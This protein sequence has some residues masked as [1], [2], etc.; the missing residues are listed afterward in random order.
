V[1][2]DNIVVF[3]PGRTYMRKNRIFI[4]QILRE[5]TEHVLAEEA[6]HHVSR[7]LRLR[8]GHPLILFNGRGGEYDAEISKKYKRNVEV[9]IK[10]FRDVDNESP[11]NITLAQGISKGQKMDFTIQKAVEMGVNRIV[12]VLTEYG[13]VQLDVKRLQKK[14]EHWNKIIISP[15]EQSARNKIPELVAPLTLDAWLTIDSGMTK[16]ILH[17]ESGGSLSKLS[18]P[19]GETT[20]LIG[21]KAGFQIMKLIRLV[22]QTIKSS[23]LAPG[24]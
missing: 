10:Q 16:I 23:A 20:L 2:K 7:V 12:P 22:K 3:W 17:P 6:A 9:H 18:K 15:C 1:Y 11:L 19:K 5:G 24:F 13:N 21:L 8:P 4:D 14:I